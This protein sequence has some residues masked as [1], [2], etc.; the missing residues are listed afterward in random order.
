MKCRLH[1]SPESGIALVIT[2]VMLAIVTVMAIVFLG[3]SQ[4]ERAS[5]K[6]GE[7]IAT[8]NYMAD[9]A[10]ERAKAEAVA[11]MAAA[12]TKLYYDLFNSRSFD[13]PKGFNTSQSATALAQPEN[14]SY[15]DRNG[16]VL[17]GQA[18]LRMLANMQYDA[19][20]PGLHRNQRQYRRL[21]VPLLPRFRSQSPNRNERRRPDTGYNWPAGDRK[22]S[23]YR[24]GPASLFGSDW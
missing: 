16:R 19:R 21:G 23:G 2:L 12:G 11:K 18:Y 24:Q 4:R 22:K 3:V 13:N 10:A 1:K 9:A 7:D 6:V 8:A 20:V 17:S 14:V 15:L 5:V